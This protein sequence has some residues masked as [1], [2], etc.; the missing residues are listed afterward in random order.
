MYFEHTINAVINQFIL[1]A[2]LTEEKFVFRKRIRYGKDADRWGRGTMAFNSKNNHICYCID[3]LNSHKRKMPYINSDDF[4]IALFVHE[5]GHYFHYSAEKHDIDRL[6]KDHKETSGIKWKYPLEYAAWQYGKSII[7]ER[8]KDEYDW[9]NRINLCAYEEVN[10]SSDLLKAKEIAYYMDVP[11]KR[12]I[13]KSKSALG[14][15]IEWPISYM[16]DFN[17]DE[18]I[19]RIGAF[20]ETTEDGYTEYFNEF[21]YLIVK[22]GAASRLIVRSQYDFYDVKACYE[23]IGENKL[24]KNIV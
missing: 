15:V 16:R 13:N 14:K 5:L 4:L 3:R 6:K 20:L 1:E 24:A 22:K 7:P 9:V 18:L 8:L 12:R 10:M 21:D 2:G 23:L 17:K 19:R 11:V